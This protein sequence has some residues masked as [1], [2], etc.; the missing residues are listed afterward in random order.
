MDQAEIDRV[1]RAVLA[2]RRRLPMWR[3]RDGW[4]SLWAYTLRPILVDPLQRRMGCPWGRH[5]Y[6]HVPA[7]ELVG[8]DLESDYP[9]LAVCELC[10]DTV[11]WPNGMPALRRDE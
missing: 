2:H 5:R 9:V 4:R 7:D 1:R 11:E 6:A 3:L 8:A 10:G